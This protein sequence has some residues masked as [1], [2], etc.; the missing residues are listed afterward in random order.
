MKKLL[1]SI[2]SAAA[3]LGAISAPAMAASTFHL[4]VPLSRSV[5]VAPDPEAIAVSLTGAALPT[6]K[7]N[8]SYTQALQGYLSITGDPGLNLSQVS[9]GLDGTLPQGLTLDSETGVI[10]GKPSTKTS[11]PASFNVVASYKGEQGST[12]Y[13][14]EVAGDRFEA[15]SIA[16]GGGAF[17]CAVIP[18]GGVKCW[19]YNA[20][21][22]LGDGTVTSNAVP[23]R[24]EG[25]LGP[26]LAVG[27]GEHHACAALEDGRMQ[28]WGYNIRG[29]LGDGS[30]INRS[31]PVLVQGLDIAP[32]TVAAG[33][34]HTCVASR[35]GAVRC[36]GFNANGE[37]GIG[38]APDQLTPVSPPISAVTQLAAGHNFSCAIT[39]GDLYCWGINSYGALGSGTTVGINTPTK[40]LGSAKYKSVSLGNFHT[41]GLTTSNTVNCWGYNKSGQ[42]GDGST[43]ITVTTPKAV[44]GLSN[45]ELLEVGAYFSCAKLAGGTNV[46]C[47][48]ANEKGQQGAPTTATV[49]TP[50]KVQ[51]TMSSVDELE[52]GGAFSC[53]RQGTD[54]YCW[55]SNAGYALGYTSHTASATP[56]SLQSIY[57]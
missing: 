1:T 12:S 22:Q 43:T 15:K 10:A 9:W 27:A 25:L 20:F 4:V 29:Q 42:V 28:C 30:K 40:V 39:G 56:V 8:T 26:V 5:N 51:H 45:V 7:V 2:A 11:E 3:L 18:D 55:G 47:W 6:A 31:T 32:V 41:C 50:R 34:N 38:A 17:T 52:L 57:N 21:G 53:A 33:S 35:E 19:G 23:A 49:L 48:G 16:S 46:Y 37:L 13:T 36:W 14:I 54:V 24:V 44:A